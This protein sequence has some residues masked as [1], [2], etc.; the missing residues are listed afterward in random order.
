MC[1][2]NYPPWSV[3][4]KFVLRIIRALSFR[5]AFNQK[6]KNPEPME[7]PDKSLDRLLAY[8]LEK[9]LQGDGPAGHLASI[10]GQNLEKVEVE[11]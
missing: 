5:I 1:N 2:S 3:I 4:G 8:S 9:V 10:F 6:K 11:G 7:D